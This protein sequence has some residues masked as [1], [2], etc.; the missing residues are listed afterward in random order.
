VNQQ[1]GNLERF[2]G[3]DP[4]HRLRLPEFVIG[5]MSHDLAPEPHLFQAV[6]ASH[7]AGGAGVQVKV[8]FVAIARPP[9]GGVVAGPFL[10]INV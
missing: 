2:A 3:Q 9:M 4:V 5:G 10:L 1:H 7:F 6:L 8:I